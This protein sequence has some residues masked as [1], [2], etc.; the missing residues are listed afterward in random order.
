MNWK[1]YPSSFKKIKYNLEEIIILQ[2]N[3]KVAMQCFI[4]I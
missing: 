1:T 3:K 4:I 2:L